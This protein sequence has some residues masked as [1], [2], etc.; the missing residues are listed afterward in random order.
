MST[1]KWQFTSRFRY[2]AFGWNS[3]LPIQRIKEA[4][5]EIK[6]FTRKDPILAAEGAVMLLEKL[7]P[8]L[9]QWIAHRVR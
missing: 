7:S 5:S 2:H 8:A 9:E 6:S 4:L 1:H 3:K